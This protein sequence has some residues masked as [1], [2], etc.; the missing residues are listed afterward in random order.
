M[1]G[2]MI[3]DGS[4]MWA[5]AHQIFRE[6]AINAGLTLGTVHKLSRQ[7]EGEGGQPKAH[8]CLLCLM[9]LPM[10]G[11]GRFENSKNHV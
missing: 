9:C 8:F 2:Q 10:K 5:F 3:R 7:P 1:A 4:T 6:M 11:G